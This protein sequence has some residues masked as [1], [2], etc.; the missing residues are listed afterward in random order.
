MAI[1]L[2]IMN[3]RVVPPLESDPMPG[4]WTVRLDLGG[5]PDNSGIRSVLAICDS[6]RE[7]EAFVAAL[8]L[9]SLPERLGA[10]LRTDA[11]TP[12]L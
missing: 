5:L 6:Q 12:A 7:A 2:P 10:R 9:A 1:T 3:L 11:P 4:I 8:E